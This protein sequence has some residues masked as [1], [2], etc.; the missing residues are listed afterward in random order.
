MEERCDGFG[1]G[2][3]L[4]RLHLHGSKPTDS[5]PWAS[6]K[7]ADRIEN[8]GSST[9]SAKQLN[10]PPAIYWGRQPSPWHLR[11]FSS[12][13]LASFWTSGAFLSLAA[14]ANSTAIFRI[15]VFQATQSF[16][17]F[18]PSSLAGVMARFT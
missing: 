17:F 5:R 12:S 8:V 1:L 11:Q 2:K 15:S 4:R 7:K 6:K 16:F 9:L 3:F 18:L 13:F 10:L 14:S